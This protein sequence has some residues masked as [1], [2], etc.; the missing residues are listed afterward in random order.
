VSRTFLIT[1]SDHSAVASSVATVGLFAA[2]APQGYNTVTD[3]PQGRNTVTYTPQ[4]HNIVT[5]IP[6]GR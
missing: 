6:Q 3:I 2:D 4:G 1:N 5:D